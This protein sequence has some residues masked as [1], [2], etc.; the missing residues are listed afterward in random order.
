MS[1]TLFSD[2]CCD[3]PQSYYTENDIHVITLDCKVSDDIFADCMVSP[4]EFHR[5]YQRI[6]NGEP[7]TTAQINIAQ[8]LAAFEP[9]LNQ[10]RDVLYIGFSSA[11]SGTYNS[12]RLACEELCERYPERKIAVIDSVSASLGQGLLVHQAM[13]LKKQ[14][15]S[16]DEV[17]QWVEENKRNLHHWFTVDDLHHLHRGG[18]ISGAATVMGTLINVKPVLYM[19]NMGR[20]IP[21]EKVHGR[22]KSLK[23]L[24]D[25]M[26]DLALDIGGTPI[27]VSHGDCPED[28]MMLVS[29]IRERFGVDVDMINYIGPVIG[30][31]SGPGTV[32][33]FFMGKNREAYLQKM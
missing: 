20:L 16:F 6:R 30:S 19:D 1:Y 27:F 15:K 17:V 11:L 3:L 5:F 8:Y 31:H 28:A 18:R 14:G 22:R 9:D 2:S 7:C 12:A 32:A 29:M 4:E 13:L 23:A 24:L 26:E 10:G 33:L 21:R 25:H